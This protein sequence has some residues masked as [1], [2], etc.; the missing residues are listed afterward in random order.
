MID[1]STIMKLR[2]LTG[3]GIVEA[4]KALE[5][6]GGDINKA[7]EALRKKGVVKAAEKGVRETREGR[8]HSYI[9]SNGKVGALLEVLCETDFVARNETFK[10]LCHDLAMQ[11]AAANPLYVSSADVPPEVVEKEKEVY[12]SG[13]EHSG[14]PAEIVNKIVEG[15]LAKYFSDVCLLNQTF[16]KDEDITV[17][18]RIKAAI[19]KLGENIR[20]RRF[21]RFSL[22]QGEP[23]VA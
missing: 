17:E 6:A 20:V 11:I 14:K 2:E 10:E 8:V 19:A 4:K 3:A 21:V 22:D 7:I 23:Q 15:K 12:S 5:A 13:V 16:I 1:A 9:H 18:E